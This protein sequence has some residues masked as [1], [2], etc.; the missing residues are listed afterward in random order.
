MELTKEERIQRILPVKYETSF[1][2][3]MSAKIRKMSKRRQ[4]I[5]LRRKLEKELLK[6]VGRKVDCTLYQE[7]I[8]VA[9]DVVESFFGKIV[10]RAL[11]LN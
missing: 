10:I 3:R 4:K 11:V 6:F 8:E 7:V 9:N 5:A 2:P 1:H